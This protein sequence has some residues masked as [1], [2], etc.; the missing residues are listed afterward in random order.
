ML[1]DS[2]GDLS[3]AFDIEPLIHSFPETTGRGKGERM[4][5]VAVEQ[6]NREDARVLAV[7]PIVIEQIEGKTLLSKIIAT[8][9][10]S[11][12]NPS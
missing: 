8:C 3:R 7:V 4:S 5:T 6:Q 1:L 10:S 2:G 12:S 9:S 11:C